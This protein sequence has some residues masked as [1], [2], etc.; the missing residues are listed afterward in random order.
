MMREDGKTAFSEDH[1]VLFLDFLGFADA[2]GDAARVERLIDGVTAVAHVQ[3][4]FEIK[5]EAQPDGGYKI[6][7]RAEITTFSDNVVVSYPLIPADEELAEVV[8]PGWE[9]MVRR[10]M[11]HIAARIVRVG[12]DDLGLLVRG[13][14]SRGR[15]YHHGAVVVGEGMVDAYRV[16]KHVAKLARV[17]VSPRITDANAIFVDTDGTRCL[18]F[19]TELMI[20]AD[21]AHGDALAWARSKLAQI[22]TTAN[23]LPA[24]SDVASKWRKFGETLRNKIKTWPSTPREA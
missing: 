20:A 19:F 18:D 16:E 10:Q 4:R 8:S 23:A 5:G 21:E 6:T 9:E 15:L 2:V 17:A 13:G 22:E 1:E 12:L 7:G 11:Q 3:Q 24:S 14:L